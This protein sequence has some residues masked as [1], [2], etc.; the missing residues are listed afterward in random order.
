ML[1][2]LHQGGIYAQKDIANQAA[3]WLVYNGNHKV[4][5]RWGIHTEYQLRRSELLREPMQYFLRLGVDYYS[6]KS[7]QFT[8]GY[9]WFHSTPYGEQPSSHTTN[10]HR[11]WQQFM[12]K[13]TIAGLE[14]IHRYRLEQRWIE[15]WT[16]VDQTNYT[17]NGF[18]FRQRV[19]YRFLI[20]HPLSRKELIDNTLFMAISDEI[21]L[22]FGK[23]IGKNV[24]DQNRFYAGLGWRFSKNLQFQLGYLNQFIIK[25]DGVH[26]ERNH[27][28]QASL[29][30]Q[31]DLSK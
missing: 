21:F 30:L 18:I 4:H 6:P 13:T 24:L 3:C 14:L 12:Y 20:N 22:G 19:R 10:E 23:G 8:T 28:L 11:L 9:G 25:T 5:E 1:I 26:I 15:N 27:T 31:A 7:G 17:E 29:T 16:S 2:A